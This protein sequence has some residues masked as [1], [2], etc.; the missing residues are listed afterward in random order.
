MLISI[1][2]GWTYEQQ[3]ARSLLGVMRR[4]LAPCGKYLESFSFLDS[5]GDRIESYEGDH[6]PPFSIQCQPKEEE[7]T[8]IIKRKEL[9]S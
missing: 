4:I 6:L 7:G 5:I 2:P 9:V 1:S 8:E 3:H